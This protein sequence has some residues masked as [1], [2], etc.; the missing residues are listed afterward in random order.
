MTRE[1]SMSKNAIAKRQWRERQAQIKRTGT[2][3]TDGATAATNEDVAEA[4]APVEGLNVTVAVPTQPSKP[5][6]LKER[7]FGKK[8]AAPVAPPIKKTVAKANSKK[9]VNLISSTLPTIIAGLIA[10]YV[11]DLLPEE[12]KPCAPSKAE[13]SAVLGPLFE[14]IG[15]RVE[16]VSKASEDAIDIANSFLAAVAY[17]ARAYVMYV[18]IKRGKEK[19]HEPATTGNNG[20]ASRPNWYSTLDEDGNNRDGLTFAE[21]TRAGNGT[22]GPVSDRP[23]VSPGYAD[24]ATGDVGIG[25]AADSDGTLSDRDIEAN[26]VSDLFKRDTVG[27]RQIGLLPVPV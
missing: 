6:S 22:G 4:V 11:Q 13:A 23:E 24:S 10:V 18:Q 12:Y 15:R 20:A 7:L 2:V 1:L 17:G 26:Q 8:Q 25:G 5:L 14:I 9:Q 19:R 21:Y 16:V 27:R 3:G